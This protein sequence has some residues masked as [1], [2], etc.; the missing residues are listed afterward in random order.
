MA[1]SMKDAWKSSQLTG[2]NSAYLEAIYEDYLANP[3]S[4]EPSWRQYFKQLTQGQTTTDRAHT[5]IQ[6][7]FIDLAQQPKVAANGSDSRL[8]AVLDLVRAYRA[9]GHRHATIDPLGLM[10]PAKTPELDL[11]YHG[12]SDSDLSANFDL[13]T[14]PGFTQTTLKQAIEKLQATY[15]SSIGCEYMHI[16]NHEERCWI[17]EQMEGQQPTISKEKKLWLLQRLTAAN[18]LEKY[19]DQQFAGQ[20]RFSLE[21][22]DSLIPMIDETLIRAC[23][24]GKVREVVIGM[25]HRGRL[26]VLVNIVGKSPEHLFSEFKGVHDESLLAGDVKYHMG[27]SSDVKVG[28]ERIHVALAFNPSHL[29][30]VAPVVEG[31]VRARQARRDSN[32]DSVLPIQIHGDAAFAGQGVVMET[33]AM[34]QLEG[35]T[36]GGSIHIVIN[37][38]V[39]FT[40]DPQDSRSS[41]YS[42]DIAK[43]IDALILH[44]NGDDAEAVLRATQIAIDYRMKF[45]KD[46]VLDLVCY[47]RHGHNEADEARATQPLMYAKIR[48]QPVTAQ[49]YAQQLIARQDIEQAEA[50]Q[51]NK[52]Y[53]DL[54]VAGKP[55]VELTEKE[56]NP[57]FVVDWEPHLNQPWD[58]AHN[59]TM[60]KQT[61]LDVARSLETL[62]PGFSPQKQV[63]KTLEDR[64]LMT[65]GEKPIN[66]GY[67]EVLAYATLLK[68]GYPIRL[69]GE[70]AQRG[71]FAHRHATIHDQK[72]GETYMPLAHID[73]NQADMT[74]INSLL[75]EEAVMAFEYGYGCSSPERLVIWEAQFGDFAN[76]AQV[77]IDQFISSAEEKWG[78]LCGLVLY[79]PHGQEGM[80]AEHS[81]AR[82]ERYLQLCAHDN[83]QVCIPSTPAQTYHMIRRQML[84]PVRKPLIVMTPKSLLRHPLAVSTFD[85]LADGQF[86]LVI[87]E[88]DDLKKPDINRVV[89]CS[90]KVYYDLLATRREHEMKDVALIRIEQLYPYPEAAIEKTLASYHNAKEFVWCQ[91]EPINQGAWRQIRAKLWHLLPQGGELKHAGREAFASPAV[92]YPALFKEQQ[93]ALVHK[94]LKLS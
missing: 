18:G 14:I 24:T 8:I 71:T 46:V 80:G 81:S 62:P 28:N 60:P 32:R 13:S 77:V 76:T 6:Q 21:G 34:S 39:G 87:D 58:I 93:Q 41:L 40:T 44:V 53:R 85:E 43:M 88:I 91:E 86:E 69:S 12:L 68:A 47:R 79:L 59:T 82:L 52:A 66:W 65:R 83:M 31:S 73:Q 61:L 56:R 94:A 51:L 70:D 2:N 57:K 35:Y 49:V 9:L 64:A 10:K 27:F 42:T 22:G 11:A 33:L 48:Q 17:R 7:A 37:N 92:G 55:V 90:G 26:N 63:G 5:P 74:I 16:S 50:D 78:R 84:R 36:T 30:I 3:E 19:L 29:E 25:A 45:N 20:K 38:Q 54:L 4:V 89:M 15:C 72:T 67:A 1:E 75:S 23:A